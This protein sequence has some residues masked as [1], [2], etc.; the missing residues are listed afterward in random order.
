MNSK[1][2]ANIVELHSFGDEVKVA[3]A[4]VGKTRVYVYVY[5]FALLRNKKFENVKELHH[6]A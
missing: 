6:D 4:T 3:T 1:N 5:Y 2:Y